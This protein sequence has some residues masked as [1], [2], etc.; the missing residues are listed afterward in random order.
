[1]R[2]LLFPFRSAA[3]KRGREGRKKKKKTKPSSG[4]AAGNTMTRD[5]PAL[6]EGLGEPVWEPQPGLAT[7]TQRSGQAHARLLIFMRGACPTRTRPC[8]SG[9]MGRGSTGRNL[10]GAEGSGTRKAQSTSGTLTETPARESF[11]EGGRGR[12]EELRSIR[13]FVR[14]GGPLCR[15][16]PLG[17]SGWAL[18]PVRRGPRCR[19]RG[20]A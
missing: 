7:F 6:G 8:P 16:P 12:E 10:E 15:P 1:M 11:G 18:L 19:R 2:S 14:C 4:P 3:Q 13:S 5:R 17:A 9:L 20:F